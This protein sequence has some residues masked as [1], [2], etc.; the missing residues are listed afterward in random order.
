MQLSINERDPSLNVKYKISGLAAIES[1]APPTGNEARTVDSGSEEEGRRFVQ[2]AV[3]VG[4]RS[5]PLARV[6]VVKAKDM[7]VLLRPSQ[8][9]TRKQPFWIGQVK[10]WIPATETA[11]IQ[12]YGAC[13]ET[14][15]WEVC[16]WGEALHVLT[17][18]MYEALPE[19]KKGKGKYRV[20]NIG[21]P[22]EKSIESLQV[23]E[24]EV[25]LAGFQLTKQFK[26]PASTRH[27]LSTL[28]Q[29]E[30]VSFRDE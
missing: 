16:I 14:L 7:I 13:D 8:V 25:F 21:K 4:S 11:V 17:E 12:W 27:M 5:R 2:A 28:L 23:Q 15:S 30:Q 26:I 6:K 3:S 24:E 18:E 29:M 1:C 9:R 10:S 20:S 19:S 22:I